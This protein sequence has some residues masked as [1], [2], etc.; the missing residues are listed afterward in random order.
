MRSK[1]QMRSKQLKRRT[2]RISRRQRGGK[3][4]VEL[5]AQ[6]EAALQKVKDVES[7]LTSVLYELMKESSEVST[8]RDRVSG[9]NLTDLDTPEGS[10]TPQHQALR[11]VARSASHRD[12]VSGMNFDDLNT[13]LGDET[14]HHQALR[15]VARSAAHR[16]RVSGMNFDDLNTPLGDETP[17]HQALRTVARFEPQSRTLVVPEDDWKFGP[18][19]NT[20]KP[21]S[22]YDDFI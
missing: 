13:P 8:H 20:A 12:R 3:P 16:D 19:G 4:L 18:T 7:V 1:Q 9:M 21:G 15:T 17:H 5:K 6:V 10:E 11:T 14:P 22:Q 2:H